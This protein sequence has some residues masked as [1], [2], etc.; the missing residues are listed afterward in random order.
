MF[1]TLKIE[2]WVVPALPSVLEKS[3]T[4]QGVR[5]PLLCVVSKKDMVKMNIQPTVKRHDLLWGWLFLHHSPAHHAHSSTQLINQRH[6]YEWWKHHCLRGYW[7]L[8]NPS[9]QE[10]RLEGL[11]LATSF[12][13]A[14]LL[15][16]SDVIQPSLP[17]V[18]LIIID[19]DQFNIY[20]LRIHSL[21][22]C[23]LW[24]VV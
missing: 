5:S 2:C 9:R 13:P 17:C 6:F 10:P 22:T 8:I 24:V 18:C 12:I 23:G 19:I 4:C 7:E 15:Q 21:E 11:L 20:W 14:L 16:L 1:W 3:C